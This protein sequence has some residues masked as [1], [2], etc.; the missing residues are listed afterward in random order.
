VCFHKA[1]K[2][3]VAEKTTWKKKVAEKTK[4]QG[5]DMQGLEDLLLALFAQ[6]EAEIIRSQEEDRHKST[7]EEHMEQVE[8]GSYR[9]FIDYLFER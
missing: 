2:K 8:P 7:F 9:K 6:R 3:R 1:S 4:E 5:P